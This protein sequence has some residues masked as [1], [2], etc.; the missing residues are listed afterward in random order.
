[1][2][3]GVNG[4]FFRANQAHLDFAVAE[5]EHLRPKHRGVGYTHK[6]H[7]CLAGDVAGDNEKPRAVGRAVNMGRLNVAV[8]LLFLLVK[9]VKIQLGSRGKRLNNVFERVVIAPFL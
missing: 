7:F 5:R 1:M 3:C 4:L 2:Q 9:P 8:N 6:L